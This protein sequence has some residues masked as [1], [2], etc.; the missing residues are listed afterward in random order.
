M[1]PHMWVGGRNEVASFKG[2]GV[3]ARAA[4]AFATPVL[5]VTSVLAW[6]TL[7]T[8][9]LPSLAS[10]LLASIVMVAGLLLLER[11]MPRPGLELRP[12]GTL[13]SDIAFTA[14][15]TVV[16]VVA[17]PLVIVPLGRHAATAV[18]AAPVWPARL[19]L[20]ASMVAAILVVD[21]TS[22][23]WHRLQHTTGGS[24]LWRIHSVHHSARHFDFWMGA[25]VHPL[26]VLGFTVVGYGLLG[27]LGAPATA[28]DMTAFFASMV[29]AV[30]HTRVDSDCSWLNRVLPFADHHVVHHSILPHDA[31]NYGNLTTLFDQLFATYRPPTPRQCSPVGAWSLAE[32]YPQGAYTFQLL[33]PFGR[34]WQRA[35]SPASPPGTTGSHPLV[36]GLYEPGQIG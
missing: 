10:S 16:A 19:P 30:H 4:R 11:A 27:A 35:T 29:G 15:T 36:Y 6:I 13:R 25:R 5:L 12:S 23:W 7:W 18:G 9:G 8:A 31:G 32:D 14:T 24:W 21:L 33:S 1:T 28:I 22:Y 20:W 26:D 3:Y 17:P 2:G 34:F